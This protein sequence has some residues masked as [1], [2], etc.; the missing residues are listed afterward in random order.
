MRLPTALSVTVGQGCQPGGRG[1]GHRQGARSRG[2]GCPVPLTAVPYDPLSSQVAVPRGG[3]GSGTRGKAAISEAPWPSQKF[4]RW[5]NLLEH[6]STMGRG[7][8]WPAGPS[9]AG[10]WLKGPLLP[11]PLEKPRAR[12]SITLNPGSP[13]TGPC[14]PCPCAGPAVG[15]APSPSP[16]ER[17]PSPSHLPAIQSQSWPD[18]K[19]GLRPL[20]PPCPS[21]TMPSCPQAGRDPTQTTLGTR[22]APRGLWSAPGLGPGVSK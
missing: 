13:G 18:L 21:I 9:G 17:P 15:P 4:T 14:P 11:S 22:G 10:P 5:W 8:P 20:R 1:S 3:L 7:T 19:A 6:A 2:P 16:R 12:P